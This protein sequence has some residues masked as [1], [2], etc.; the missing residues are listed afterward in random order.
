MSRGAQTKCIGNEGSGQS[1][2]SQNAMK[3]QP[4][5]RDRFESEP[6]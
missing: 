1:S 6:L 2:Q 5:R 4:Q 3:V